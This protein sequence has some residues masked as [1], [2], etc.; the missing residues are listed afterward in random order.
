MQTKQRAQKVVVIGAGM[1]GLTAAAYLARDGHK[2]TVF[3]QFPEIGGVTATLHQD[4][5]GWDLGPMLLEGFAPDERGG[6]ILKD[7]GV[8]DRVTWRTGDRRYVFPDFDLRKPETYATPK[9]RIERLAQ[10]FPAESEGLSRYHRFYRR[11][12]QLLA[13]HV[14]ADLAPTSLKP[15][16]KLLMWPIYR[17]IKDKESWS[18]RQLMDHF[19]VDTRLKA[20]F[21]AILADFTVRPSRFP[22]LGI[23]TLNVETSFD[24]RVPRRLVGPGRLPSYHYV[25][26]GCSHLAEAVAGAIRYHGGRIITGAPVDKILIEGDRATGVH[27]TSGQVETADVVVASGG[28][29]E[30]FFNLAG[31]VYLPTGFT[32]QI[33]ELERMASVFMVH[34]GTK[35]DPAALQPGL[36][37]EPLTYYYGTYDVEGGVAR[38]L[39]GVYHEGR[40]GFLIYIPSM[41]SPELA[42]EGHHAITI[43]TIA[44]NILTGDEK[45]ETEGATWRRQRERMA[46][47][48]LAE[49]ENVLPGLR[50]NIET[51]VILTPEDFRTRTHLDH[52][53]FGGRAPVLGQEGPGYATPIE[54]LW[55]IGAQSKSGGGV[56]NVMIGA[57]DAVRLIQRQRLT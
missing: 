33:E 41:H 56:Q 7:L 38:C 48:L 37:P 21:T 11:V 12:M 8:A 27:L 26:G 36:H 17:Q 57:R 4:G 43:Y 32:Y 28:A 45:P 1:A 5:Y 54:R 52:H 46:D 9:W 39:D 20:V 25:A 35:M 19:F 49:A 42:P 30:T 50:E 6:R 15:L 34:L 47:K 3:E 2:V 14:R 13:L 29:Q 44:P 24:H 53:A 10:H 31:R 18:A 22:G 51:R 23:P 16:I 55:F 40:D